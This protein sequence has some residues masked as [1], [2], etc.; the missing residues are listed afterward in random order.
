[1]AYNN[2]KV[3]IAVLKRLSRMA[4]HYGFPN[5]NNSNLFIRRGN[6]VDPGQDF[7]LREQVVVNES[8][9]Y[10]H[11]NY[12]LGGGAVPRRYAPAGRHARSPTL[13]RGGSI[14]LGVPQHFRDI[15]ERPQLFNINAA[16]VSDFNQARQHGDVMGFQNFDL[17][18]GNLNLGVGQ[19]YHR[20]FQ[21]NQIELV[22]ERARSMELEAQLRALQLDRQNI[23]RGDQVI[24]D[25]GLDDEEAASA[26][27]ID[28]RADFDAGS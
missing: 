28:D 9:D 18:Q 22:N 2:F 24:L 8:F 11:G 15:G 16:P 19:D 13:Q 7:N 23:P 5:V 3:C 27:D 25:P 12:T 6:V 21:D 1:M 4:N 20:A 14:G 26:N 17:S 10:G